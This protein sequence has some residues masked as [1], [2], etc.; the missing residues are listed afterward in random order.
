[1]RGNT[2]EA[3]R[4]AELFDREKRADSFTP[5]H[6][7]R[8]DFRC[9]AI[10]WWVEPESGDYPCLRPIAAGQVADSALEGALP[11]AEAV[12]NRAEHPQRAGQP[13]PSARQGS[14]PT[15][16]PLPG[17]RLPARVVLQ[18]FPLVYRTFCS[19]PAINTKLDR[20]YVK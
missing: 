16:N 13:E 4:R 20:S 17:S 6:Q 3:I 18:E 2:Q 11:A 7:D 10:Q 8:S 1:M 9:C 5:G 14:A 15:P 12:Q 19:S